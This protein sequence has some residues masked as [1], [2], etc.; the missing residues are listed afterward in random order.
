MII[1]TTVGM[2]HWV[3]EGDVS[4]FQIRTK[5]EH[6]KAET[7]SQKKNIQPQTNFPGSYKK[8]VIVF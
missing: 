5:Q 1:K 3:S 7:L 8:K 2:G 6:F 4:K